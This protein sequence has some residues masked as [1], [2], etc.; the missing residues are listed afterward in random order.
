MPILNNA[1]RLLEKPLPKVI[2]PKTHAVA[3]YSIA[4]LF[5]VGAGLFWKKS[6]RAA[7]GSLICAGAEAGIAALTDYPG[8]L[9]PAISFPLHKKSIMVFPV[10]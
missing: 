1:I 4:L 10:W 8:G 5:L 9:K 6:K 7:I 3:D 2:S